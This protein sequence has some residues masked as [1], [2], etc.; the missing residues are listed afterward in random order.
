MLIEE[1]EEEEEALEA[2][3]AILE[4][5]AP[6]AVEGRAAA[7]RQLGTFPPAIASG[8]AAPSSPSSGASLV[9]LRP[10]IGHLANTHTAP[11]TGADIVV[12]LLTLSWMSLIKKHK[13]WLW[14]GVWVKIVATT[15][16]ISSAFP[17]LFAERLKTED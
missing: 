10:G 5:E 17:F 13:K 8:E 4:E 2:A 9:L 14:V 15:F 6:T 11:P 16:A 1:E 7:L 3:A 12:H